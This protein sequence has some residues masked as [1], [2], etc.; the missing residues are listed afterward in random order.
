MQNIHSSSSYLE[1]FERNHITYDLLPDLTD[2]WLDRMGFVA[3]GDRIR[4]EKALKSLKQEVGTDFE[5]VIGRRRW[6]SR[7]FLAHREKV[8]VI[9]EW[10]FHGDDVAIMVVVCTRMIS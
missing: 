3:L 1:L 2:E 6:K 7:W 4:L 5:G 8:V 9:S 10:C